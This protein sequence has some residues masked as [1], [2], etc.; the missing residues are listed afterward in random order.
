MHSSMFSSIIPNKLL[1]ASTPD[2]L[3][4]GISDAL[5]DMIPSFIAKANDS[6]WH[7]IFGTSINL[8]EGL[9]KVVTLNDKY[10]TAHPEMAP[11]LDQAY[12]YLT[13]NGFKVDPRKYGYIVYDYYDVDT[14][15]PV[16]SKYADQICDNNIDDGDYHSCT[17]VVH[18]DEVKG[19]HEIYTEN[20]GFFYEG[21]TFVLPIASKMTILRT[22]S[23]V[24]N[25]QPHIGKG[26]ESR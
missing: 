3:N 10:M 16:E 20:P 26:K 1:I 23:L 21:K 25:I 13:T 12:H 9:C 8:N 14:D 18:K 17:F 19:N 7:R 4:K 5:D 11:I 15:F 24:Y 22:G 2:S 6:L